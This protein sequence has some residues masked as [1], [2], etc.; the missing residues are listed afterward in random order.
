MF[1]QIYSLAV[2]GTMSDLQ[3]PLKS[4]IVYISMKLFLMPTIK[5]YAKL[6]IDPLVDDHIDLYLFRGQLYGIHKD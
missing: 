2:N 4:L 5:D 3:G 1:A 6:S